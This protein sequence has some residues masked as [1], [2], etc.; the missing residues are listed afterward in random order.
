MRQTLSRGAFAAAAATGILSLYGAPALADTHAEG[1]ATNSPGVLSGNNVQAPIE[2]P[3]NACG[4]TI[5]A[6]SA[7]NAASGN[8]CVN[9]SHQDDRSDHRASG[10]SQDR[11]G[12]GGGAYA[13]GVAKDSPG[14]ASGNNVQAPVHAPVNAC[15]NSVNVVGALNE[16]SD[17]TCVNGSHQDDRSDHRASGTSQDRS[18]GGAYAEGV[19][20]GSPGVLSGNLI[21]LPV[22]APVNACGNSVNVIGLLNSAYGNDCGNGHTPDEPGDEPETPLSPPD[23]THTPPAHETHTPPPAP[24]EEPPHLAETGSDSVLA[25]SAA[26]ASLLV[27]GALLYRRGHAARR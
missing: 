18:D 24:G 14:V 21:Q 4:N 11:S 15:G 17:N 10:T 9:G 12:G 13:E 26:G 3:V 2:V 16:A 8:T 27:G 25:A 6:A 1:A 5:G 20:E 22:H 19:A 23:R 7:L